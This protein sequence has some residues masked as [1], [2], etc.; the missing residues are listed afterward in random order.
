MR[1]HRQKF[2]L[3]VVAAVVLVQAAVIMPAAAAV[4]AASAKP[5]ATPA[6]SAAK[7]TWVAPANGGKAING[8]IVTPFKGTVAQPARTFNSTALTQ[9]INNL[10]NGQTYTFKVKARNA[11][12]TGANSPASNSVK[13]GTPVAPAKPLVAPGNAL[14][15]VNWKAPSNNGSAITGYVVTPY[16]GTTAQPARTFNSASLVQNV[17]GL[18]NGTTYTFKVAAKNA[19]GTGPQSVASGT[20]K[21]T[22]QPTLKVATDPTL[23][24]IVVNAYGMTMYMFGPD[25]DATPTA[26]NVSGALRVAWPYWTWG[27]TLTAGAGLTLAS[28]TAHNQTDGTRLVAYNGHLLY[29]WVNDHVPGDVTGHCVNN[30]F[31]VDPAGNQIAC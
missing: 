2:G 22:N 10:T 6:N 4:P 11:D 1:A 19:R 27:G 20:V 24:Q 31:A 26:S 3:V 18:T 16:I 5:K 15:R 17:T 13:V 7:V 30:F 8:Y 29:G 25:A 28:V 9:T 14:A 12:G 21:P 23:G